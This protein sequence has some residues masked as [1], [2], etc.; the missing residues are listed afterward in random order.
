M[1]ETQAYKQT[2]VGLI[3]EDWEV[4]ELGEI[5]KFSKGSGVRKDEALSG[6]LP[7]IRYGEIYTKHN[8]YIKQF[9]SFISRDVSNTAKRLKTGDILFAGSGETKEEIMQAVL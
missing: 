7:C 6:E 5:G 3:P 9:Y 1:K 8:D 2:E 4:K